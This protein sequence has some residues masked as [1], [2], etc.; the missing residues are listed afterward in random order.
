MQTVSC[1]FKML[2]RVGGIVILV[3]IIVVLV[4]G[5]VSILRAWFGRNRF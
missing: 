4:W 3:V 5:T 1:T 2:D